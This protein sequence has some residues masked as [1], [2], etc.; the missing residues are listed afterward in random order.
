MKNPPPLRRLIVVSLCCY[1]IILSLVV[2]LH[3][4]LVNE[5]AESLIWDS[6]LK[7]E[8]AYIK[9]K[10]AQDKEFDWSGL[11]VFQWH[12]ERHSA[13]IPLQFQALP[14]GIHDEIRV[15]KKQFAV[16][17]EVGA[18]GRKILALDITDIENR[19]FA[20]VAVIAASV[21]LVIVILTAVSFYSVDRLLRPL[22][23]MADDISS[24][25]PDGGGR[26]ISINDKSVHET[27][28][29]AAA[30]NGF[31]D[32]I[33]D[34][35]ERER[36]FINMAS[37]ELRTPIAVMSGATEVALDHPDAT[38]AIKQHLLRSRRIINQ[39]EDLVVILLALARSPD[40]LINN[41]EHIDIRDEVPTIV[42]D[43][44]HLCHGK[45]LSIAVELE[46]S[47]PV[48]APLHIVRI[49]IGNLVR[50]AIENCDQGVIRIYSD[51]PGTIT[52]DDPGQGM[53]P[54]EMSRLYTFMAKSGR[55]T[56]GGIGIDLIMRI[57][58]HFGWKLA[59]ESI[60]GRGIK[61]SLSFHGTGADFETG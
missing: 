22:T 12:D 2:S 23:Q 18:E 16:L 52:T 38:P 44:M 60:T 61:A 56:S 31:T 50:N 10:I 9:Q 27:Y 4:H 43:H 37:H 3:G 45:D 54:Q 57:C 14:E 15:D 20:V 39:M 29:I 19:E 51:H 1:T 40:T 30:I 59:F 41:A 24:L 47:I 21:I 33:R 26:K 48:F 17:V 25:R 28:T 42:A 36:N 46:S 6:M 34:H 55:Q 32:R 7:S 13:S 49:A 35:I 58:D 53:T 11:D 8:M 5:H